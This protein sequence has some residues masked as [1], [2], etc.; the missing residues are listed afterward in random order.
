MLEKHRK[1][2]GSTLQ[3]AKGTGLSNLVMQVELS[4]SSL[5]E[6]LTATLCCR[7]TKPSYNAFIGLDH[8]FPLSDVIVDYS[9]SAPN[10]C[11]RLEVMSLD[12]DL[13]SF[14]WNSSYSCLLIWASRSQSLQK[15]TAVVDDIILADLPVEFISLCLDAKESIAEA[16][17]ACFVD[18]LGEIT[19]QGFEI[20]EVPCF[21]LV[22]GKEIY[23]VLDLS[24][25][26]LDVMK[27]MVCNIPAKVNIRLGSLVPELSMANEQYHLVIFPDPANDYFSRHLSQILDENPEIASKIRV[28]V[29][30]PSTFATVHYSPGTFIIVQNST[31]VFKSDTSCTEID[32]ILKNLVHTNTLSFDDFSEKKSRFEY[33]QS[34][35][36]EKYPFCPMPQTVFK[37]KKT[38]FLN[39]ESPEEYAVKVQGSYLTVHKEYIEEFFEIL[40]G[41]FS[42]AENC[43]NY[44]APSHTI[45]PGEQCSVC[46]ELLDKVHYLC[47]YCK[48]AVYVCQNCTHLHPVFRFTPDV[49]GLDSL[50]WGAFNLNVG[51][52][53][54]GERCDIICNKCGE[55]IFGVWWKCA[56]CSD[57]DACGKC[58]SEDKMHSKSHIL[59]RMVS[60]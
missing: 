10:P 30:T 17:I 52:T 15:L 45:S 41:F 44:E 38:F 2:I 7:G 42:Y 46:D 55:K 43:V 3:S 50:T 33:S 20:S 13:R 24:H 40:T 51:E 57:F 26:V 60:N 34:K 54:G 56:V 23:A 21:V 16:W 39:S 18:G 6:E 35:W 32:H 53:E 48:P 59:I 11:P 22:K 8:P 27:S 47:V 19:E 5:T 36:Q 1:S 49:K 58:V 14:Q 29:A 31:I 25:R 28:T 4:V 12:N 37:F 9:L